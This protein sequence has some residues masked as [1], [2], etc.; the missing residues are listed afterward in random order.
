MTTF[1]ASAFGVLAGLLAVRA[2]G[3][4]GYLLRAPGVLDLESLRLVLSHALWPLALALSFWSVAWG[5]GRRALRAGGVAEE[6]IIAA[7]L[8][9]GLLGQ[10]VFVLGWGGLLRPWS[11]AVLAAAAAGIASMGVPRPSWSVPRPNPLAGLAVGLLAFAAACAF[12]RALAPP[13]DW[14]VR[15]YHLA[16]P[17]LALK[18][19]RMTPLPW[20]LHSHWPHLMEALYALPLAA[21][22]DGAAALIHLGAAGLLVA[23]VFGVARRAAGPAAAWSAALLIA[24][25]PAFLRAAGAAHADAAAALF[26]FAAAGA[27]ARWEEQESRGWLAT[28][29]LLWLAAVRR[30]PRAAAVFLACGLA[31]VGPWLLK[32]WLETGDPVW[33]F[34]SG[35]LGRPEAAALAARNQISNRWGFPPPFWA[36][37]QDG[38]GFLLLPLVGLLALGRRRAS[39]AAPLERRLWIPAPLLVLLVLR[40]HAA[41]RYLMPLWPALAVAAGR[42]AAGAFGAGRPRAAAAAVLV[43]AGAVPIV[44]ASPNNEL[45]AV[46]APRSLSAPGA[47][48]RALWEDRTIGLDS[49][50]REARAALPSGAR[51]LLFREIRGY[52]AGFDYQWGDPMNQA[53]VDYRAASGPDALFARL[54]AL[55]ITH[56]LENAASELYREDPGY[57]DRRTLALMAECLRRHALP[58]LSRRG[59]VLHRLLELPS[60]GAG[61]APVRRGSS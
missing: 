10:A 37:T 3:F 52:G 54:R 58:L 21:R 56:V 4:W 59:L 9:L 44:L 25:Q 40:E 48:R 55:G 45:F 51:V 15:A 19:G 36:L 41:W 7:A 22:R 30:R 50:Y 14:D 43:A 11:L 13:A 33:P 23:G 60:R 20:M 2:A 16:L 53:L 42:A 26:A 18:A 46:L 24:A 47:E 6:G 29:G 1:L 17:E 39:A 49:F 8:G 28:A 38:P 35:L 34:W 57:Y 27:L 31:V 32:T 5:L 61:P 12:L